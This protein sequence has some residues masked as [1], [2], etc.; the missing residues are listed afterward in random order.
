[1]AAVTPHAALRLGHWLPT[2]SFSLPET[3]A[4][5]D[6]TIVNGLALGLE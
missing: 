1:M 3:G 2:M 4:T 5:R 6:N